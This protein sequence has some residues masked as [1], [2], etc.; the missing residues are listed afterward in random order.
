[1]FTRSIK[2]LNGTGDTTITWTDEAD[3][4]MKEAIQKKLDQGYVFFI[5][6]PKEPEWMRRVTKASEIKDKSVLM[7]DDDMA[8]VFSGANMGAMYDRSDENIDTVGRSTNA[9]EIARSC[10]IG[11]PQ[12]RGG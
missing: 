7:L 1:M 3:E 11:I 10:S 12:V 8:K 4:K 5:T 2:L 9:A 6:K